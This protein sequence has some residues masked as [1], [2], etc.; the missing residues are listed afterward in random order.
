[1]FV[2]KKAFGVEQNG[3]VAWLLHPA[4]KRVWR[5]HE[6]TKLTPRCLVV[7]DHDNNGEPS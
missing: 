5:C 7:V 4:K 2:A 1:M 6:A 3:A